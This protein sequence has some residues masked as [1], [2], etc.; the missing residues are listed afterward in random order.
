[1]LQ[2]RGAG[3]LSKN[4]RRQGA[5]FASP[6]PA[7]A[8]LA[9]CLIAPCRRLDLRD[10]GSLHRYARHPHHPRRERRRGARNPPPRLPPML[11]RG[12]P[13]RDCCRRGLLQGHHCPSGGRDQAAGKHFESQQHSSAPAPA[14]NGEFLQGDTLRKNIV[15]HGANVRFH[16]GCACHHH[17][18][19]HHHPPGEGSLA[20]KPGPLPLDPHRL[21]GKG[22]ARAQ[23]P[24]CKKW[25]SIKM[26]IE[27]SHRAPVHKGFRLSSCQEECRGGSAASRQTFNA[28]KLVAHLKSLGFPA[29]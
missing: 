8:R 16:R 19:H 24:K 23:G 13:A 29:W 15:T 3:R 21:H 5:L 11:P 26:E 12:N 25:Q 4:G 28:P 18:H 27:S 2:Q 20:F 10:G 1:M 14:F 7:I 22:T 9:I 17:H 6:P